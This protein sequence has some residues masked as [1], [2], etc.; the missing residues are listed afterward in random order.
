[1][2]SKGRGK[3]KSWKLLFKE[4]L[5]KISKLPKTIQEKHS[6]VF[7]NQGVTNIWFLIKLETAKAILRLPKNTLNLIFNDLLAPDIDAT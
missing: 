7:T 2:N 1:M 5:Q 3:H 4:Q 6:G